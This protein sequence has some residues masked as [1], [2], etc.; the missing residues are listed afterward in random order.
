[1]V[2]MQTI[3]SFYSQIFC[4]RKYC[5]EREFITSLMMMSKYVCIALFDVRPNALFMIFDI[6]LWRIGRTLIFNGRA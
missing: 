1:M 4:F 3:F 6:I 2:K 5:F